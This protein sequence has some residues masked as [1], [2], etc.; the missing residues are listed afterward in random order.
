MQTSLGPASLLM[1]GTTINE[2]HKVEATQGG[3]MYTLSQ[4]AHHGNHE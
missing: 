2:F 4:A 1:L 3:Y